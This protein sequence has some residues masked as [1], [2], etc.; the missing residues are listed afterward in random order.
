MEK[1]KIEYVANGV[2]KHAV[3]S[4]KTEEQARDYVD[5]MLQSLYP[6]K[7]GSVVLAKASQDEGERIETNR[8]ETESA[9]V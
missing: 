4:A 1:F 2:K 7:F 9:E 8:G 5:R 3:I 6:N